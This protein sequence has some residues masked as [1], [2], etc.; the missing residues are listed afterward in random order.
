MQ[1]SEVRFSSAMHLH[2]H[3]FCMRVCMHTRAR[4]PLYMQIDKRSWPCR[5]IWNLEC[6]GCV[7]LIVGNDRKWTDH[8]VCAASLPF[9]RDVYRAIDR[10]PPV[11]VYPSPYLMRLFHSPPSSFSSSSSL[12]IVR[13]LCLSGRDK[14]LRIISLMDTDNMEPIENPAHLVHQ[15]RLK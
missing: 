3:V 4:A 7:L 15:N 8:P 13:F 2:S 6:S 14:L 5:Q 1:R 9:G 11:I 12:F 10:N